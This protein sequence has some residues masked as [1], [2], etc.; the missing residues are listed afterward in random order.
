MI[1]FV[2]V[3]NIVFALFVSCFTLPRLSATPA[4]N[5]VSASPNIIPSNASTAITITARITDSTLIPNSV[6]LLQVGPQGSTTILG[7][8]RD[9]GSEGDAVAG[10]HIYTIVHS[11]AIPT[12]QIQ[13]QVSAAFAGAL[14]RVLSSS[15]PIVALTAPP[16]FTLNPGPLST[17]GPLAFNNF[18][19]NYQQGAVIPQ[20]GAEIDVTS[21][22]LPP[23][24]LSNF[25]AFELQGATITS[26]AT[27][28]VSGI[29]CTQV[30][31][32]DA[33]TATVSY[34]NEAVYCPGAKFLYKFY[35]SYNSGDSNEASYLTSLQQLLSTAKLSQ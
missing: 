4:L 13:L 20:N 6:N 7:Q 34:K 26:T 35:L 12:G 1:R 11:F 16:M 15:L 22:P 3:L 29:A 30:F 8:L 5:V 28:S 9:D 24:P 10:D 14:R 32:T 25:I 31:Y 17:G 18:N 27:V 21:V 23:P 2:I 33:F 19:S